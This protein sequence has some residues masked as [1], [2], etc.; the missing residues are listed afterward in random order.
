[1]PAVAD[2]MK[3]RYCLGDPSACARLLADA[4]ARHP[5]LA[6]EPVKPAALALLDALPIKPPGP[7]YSGAPKKVSPELVT[8][9]LTALQRIDEGLDSI[10]TSALAQQA[11]ARFLAHGDVYDPDQILIPAALA[12]QSGEAPLPANAPMAR[13]LQEAMITLLRQ[14]IA[15]SLEPPADWC[16]PAKLKC[17][18]THCGEL[19]RFLD[20]PTDST[21][22]LKAAKNAREHVTYEIRAAQCDL[23]LKTETRGSPHTLVCTKNQASYAKRLRQRAADSDNLHALLD[24]NGMRDTT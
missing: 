23:D 15:E 7:S 2:M 21:W 20:S 4:L 9:T 10:P 11:L 13:L 17:R 12:V 24:S 16:R 18:C 19:S 6:G 8:G 14:R 5:V 1:M 3:K 22:R